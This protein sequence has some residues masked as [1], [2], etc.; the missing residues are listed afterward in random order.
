MAP[1]HGED[2][3]E[4]CKTAG[5][6]PVF[7]V[8]GDGRYRDDLRDMPLVTIDPHDARDHDDAECTQ[9]ILCRR[10]FVR[11]GFP[12]LQHDQIVMPEPMISDLMPSFI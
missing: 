11:Q 12:I 4:L 5:I 6:H 10:D 1:D 2:D 8:M 3:F 9:R 7:A